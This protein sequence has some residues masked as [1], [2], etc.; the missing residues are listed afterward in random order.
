MENGL[1][2]N[3]L[4]ETIIDKVRKVKNYKESISY[5]IKNIRAKQNVW[6]INLK[7]NK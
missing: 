2:D 3:R 4:C 1:N 5:I 7:S 6:Y